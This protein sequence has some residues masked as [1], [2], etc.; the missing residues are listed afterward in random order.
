MITRRQAI[1][2]ALAAGSMTVLG[3]GGGG[4]ASEEATGV[5]TPAAPG[6]PDSGPTSAAPPP[7]ITAEPTLPKSRY[8]TGQTYLFQP[9]PT[10]YVK[11]RLPGG[12]DRDLDLIGPNHEYVDRLTGWHWDQVGGDWIDQN[13]VR[14]GTR[15]W[16]SVLANAAT[17]G[18]A[19]APYEIDVT[20]ALQFVRTRNRWCAFLLRAGTA[21]RSIAALHQ[22]AHARPALAVEYADGTR[23]TLACRIVAS[24]RTGSNQPS[25]TAAEQRLPAFLEFQ[26]PKRDVSR[27]T[28]SFVVTT[29]A[30]HSNPLIEGFLLDPPVN[31]NRVDLGVADGAGA[32]DAGLDGHASILGAHRYLDGTAWTDFATPGAINTGAEREFDPA[33]W[34]RGPNDLT[35]LP[36]RGLGKWVSPHDGWSLIPST[37]TGEAFEPLAPGLGAVRMHMPPREGIADG[38]VGGYGGTQAGNGFIYLPESQFGRLG[39]IFVR[40]Y[41]RLGTIGGDQYL[42]PLE[43]TY[44]V[45]KS[46]TKT[47]PSWVDNAGKFGIMP[48]HVTS[49]G[50]V[51]GSAGGGNGWQMRLRWAD[52]DASL[53]GPDEGG[54]AAGL[55]LYDFY[56]KNP[57]GH[58]Y[59]VDQ[60]R[61][62]MFGQRGGMGGTLYANRW[63]C[64]EAE[65][66]LNSVNQPAVLTDGS[67]HVV[68]G[69]RQYWTP[70]GELRVWID[71]RLALERT[72]MVFR[73][74]PLLNVAYKDTQIRPCREL[75][76]RGLWLNWFHGGTTPN[77][78]E[79]VSFFT[80]LAWGQQYIGPMKL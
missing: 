42:R 76:I 70:D 72:G 18:T 45:Y 31:A 30:S 11:S 23:E 37:Y 32:L 66:K 48:E 79:R 19:T 17:G 78:H 10:R 62:T 12:K 26:R 41:F 38:F 52:C 71:G 56:F 16:F 25:T 80:G 73:S 21:Q 13:E 39:R 55:H 15:A 77:V 5:D 33:I 29:H 64:I 20:A 43:K 14:H 28:L 6:T 8:R 44:Q 63:Y 9:V 60:P 69:V 27:A 68:N 47:D 34:G 74:L 46:E 2:G 53:G 7:P 35:K 75:G 1:R 3:C 57:P 22:T 65:V 49:Y 24:A 54:V 67:P 40:H 36:H 59:T 4:A 50:G 51:S 61:A 58:N